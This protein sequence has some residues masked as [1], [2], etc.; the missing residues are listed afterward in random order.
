MKVTKEQTG[1]LIFVGGIAVVGAYVFFTVKTHPIVSIAVLAGVVGMVI[2][3]LKYTK[4][5]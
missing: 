3:Y 1:L 5:I 4:K 2:G